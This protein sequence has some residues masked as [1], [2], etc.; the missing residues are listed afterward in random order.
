[1]SVGG[2][3]LALFRLLLL[4]TV[5]VAVALIS[6]ITTIRFTIH[7]HQEIMPNFVGRSLEAGQRIATGLGLEFKIEGK[8]FNSQFPANAIVS[9]VPAAGTRVKMGQHVHVLVSLGQ[10]QVKVPDV[11]GASARAAQIKAIQDGLAVGDIAAIHWPS[12]QVDQVV[13]QDPP[14]STNEVHS[15]AL[16]VLIS[17]GPTPQAYE[18]PDFVGRTLGEIQRLL[19][20]HGFKIRSTTL[21]PA[22]GIQ[23]GNIVGQSPQ[24]GSKIDADTEFSFQVA[25]PPL[26]SAPLQQAPGTTPPASPASPQPPR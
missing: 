12:S 4:F 14:A 24:P 26:S 20:E 7:G 25:G 2:R 23:A 19:Q 18:C 3:I 16:N 10:P 9:Q 22:P 17:L 13:A 15:P 6:A 5:L 8:V 11:T 1:M 21:V